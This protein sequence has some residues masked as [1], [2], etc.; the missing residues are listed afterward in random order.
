MSQDYGREAPRA[1]N[2]A[3]LRKPARYL[4]MI[5]SGGVG[6]ALLFLETRE[7]VGD[8]DA[9]TEEAAQMTAGLV[10]SKSAAAPEWD[11][12]LEGHS[13]AERSAADVYTFDV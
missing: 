6:T 10:P 8:F 1:H 3:P 5:E 2:H 9:G 11:H 7:R 4:V 13:A 12:A